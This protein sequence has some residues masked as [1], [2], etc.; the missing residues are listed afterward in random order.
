GDLT[1]ATG[2]ADGD[3]DRLIR[4]GHILPHTSMGQGGS[5]AANDMRTAF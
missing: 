4:G 2:G 3:G 1:C 5:P